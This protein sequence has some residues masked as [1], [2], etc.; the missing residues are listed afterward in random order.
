MKKRCV[1]GI[2][3]FVYTTEKQYA[4]KTLSLKDLEYME[5]LKIKKFDFFQLLKFDI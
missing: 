1:S 2:I 3:Y 4:F 5:N